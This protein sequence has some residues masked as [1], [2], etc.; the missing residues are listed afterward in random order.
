[1]LINSMNMYESYSNEVER[2][3]YYEYD[4]WH[5]FILGFIRGMIY[6]MDA[7]SE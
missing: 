4:H 3:Y 7:G 1:M 6:V 2:E 5:Y